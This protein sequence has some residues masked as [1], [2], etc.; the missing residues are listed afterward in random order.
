MQ[1]ASTASR[2][3]GRAG[4]ISVEAIVQLLPEGFYPHCSQKRDFRQDQQKRLP[5][6]KRTNSIPVLSYKI[7]LVHS[8]YLCRKSLPANNLKKTY[9]KPSKEQRKR[10]PPPADPGTRLFTGDLY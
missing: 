3:S 8:E 6:Q 5:H 9:S 10:S 4:R 2:S 1:N 7:F